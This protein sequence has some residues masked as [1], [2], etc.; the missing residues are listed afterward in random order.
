[1][2]PCLYKA[3]TE[4]RKRQ[5]LRA[6]KASIDTVAIFLPEEW[7]QAMAVAMEGK[8]KGLL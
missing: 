5:L 8:E 6:K 4:E 2:L 7:A 3:D 1:M